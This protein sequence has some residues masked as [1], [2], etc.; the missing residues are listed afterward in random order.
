MS[1]RRLK[2]SWKYSKMH[3]RFSNVT[4]NL[5]HKAKMWSKRFENKRLKHKKKRKERG[6]KYWTELVRLKKLRRKHI[7]IR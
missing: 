1:V 7:R 2:V 3:R 4:H 5:P 6:R